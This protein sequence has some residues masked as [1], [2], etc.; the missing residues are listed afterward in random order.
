MKEKKKGRKVADG[1]RSRS[2]F[3]LDFV[4]ISSL[5]LYCFE[6]ILESFS[7]FGQERFLH[8]LYM[9]L[10]TGGWC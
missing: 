1:R 7:T 5:L 8:P 3:A 2:L 9:S 10:V 4:W 6:Y